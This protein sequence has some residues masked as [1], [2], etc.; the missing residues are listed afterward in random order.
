VVGIDR[1]HPPHEHGSSH[2]LTRITRQAIG[3]GLDYAPLALRSHE[4]WRELEAE[5]GESLLRQIGLMLIS[6]P[7]LGGV[8]HG[9]KDFLERT[10]E[11]AETFAIAHEVFDA[12]AV[13]ARWPQFSLADDEA[14]FF[15]P[16]AGLLHPERCIAAQL[17]AARKAGAAIH[18]GESVLGLEIAPGGGVRVVTDQRALEAGRV[19]VCA[20]AWTGGLLG[21]RWAK[22]LRIYRQAMHW[23]APPDSAAFA[24]DRFPAFIWMHGAGPSEWFYGLPDEGQGVKIADERFIVTAATPEGIDRAVSRAEAL[25]CH[26]A[27]AQG[28]IAGL[29]PTWLRSSACLY[30]QAP[31]SRFLIGPDPERP[32]VLVVSACSGHG[33]KHAPAIGEAVA[34]WALSG[35]R[36]K[37]LAPF[38]PDAA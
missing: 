30:T 27:H 29:P 38:A 19:I 10:L 11:A 8:H 1:H 6:R 3:E 14:A 32:E 37:I 36:P 26:A 22:Q 13:R 15:E 16:G 18:A 28:R 33:F 9:A 4:I 7:R 23:F 5:T 24:G 35:T 12:A 2:G 25:A 34:A 17:Q 20:G 31:G 21:G